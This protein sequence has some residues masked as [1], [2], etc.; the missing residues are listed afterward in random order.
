V[1]M[2][3]TGRGTGRRHGN[4]TDVVGRERKHHLYFLMLFVAGRGDRQFVARFRRR[5][6]S[7]RLELI[8]IGLGSC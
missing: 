1:G 7:D 5:S 3:A 4:P 2:D 8:S 6:A